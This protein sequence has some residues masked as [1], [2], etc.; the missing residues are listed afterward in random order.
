[1]L[2][3]LILLSI[4][5]LFFAYIDYDEQSYIDST[6]F[7]SVP[8]SGLVI[9]TQTVPRTRLH[10][11]SPGE[12]IITRSNRSIIN[13]TYS[14]Y[15]DAD[16]LSS[17][18]IVYVASDRLTAQQCNAQTSCNLNVVE[19][20]NTTTG[21][22]TRL[23]SRVTP[24]SGHNPYHDV[25]VLNESHILVA[26]TL[27]DRI[28][29]VNINS[30]IITWEWDAQAYLPVGA[31]D[32]GFPADWTHLNDVEALA[33]GRIMVNLR[34]QDQVVFVNRSTGVIDER[35]LGAAGN[36]SILYEQ[37]NP[38]YLESC[39]SVLVADSENNR[40]IEYQYDGSTYR[41]TWEWSDPGLLWPRDADRAPDG[42]TL[43][44]DS[45]GNRVIRVARDGSILWSVPVVNPYEAELMGTGPESS[46]GVCASSANLSSQTV[47]PS[48]GGESSLQV[49]SWNTIRSLIPT[50]LLSGIAF[51]L[52]VWVGI[53][54]LF[55]IGLLGTTSI[56][57]ISLEIY[58]LSYSIQVQSP[59]VL[60]RNKDD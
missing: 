10:P 23:F 16:P 30:G 1:V 43:I 44:T 35:T 41:Q 53:D 47:D 38:D 37:H 9:T 4:A 50:K 32:S 3:C 29:I 5:I 8:E 25:D 45:N 11:S 55:T 48:T 22:T 33:D 60:I 12:I 39:G 2:A 34:N 15:W 7:Q 18:S 26:D 28:F 17:N 24:S 14:S 31:G 56:S 57:W 51:I 6:E 40:V 59:V 21:N 54:Q 42:T 49:R 20:L 19:V 46:G 13:Q 52:P 58:W 27:N 36:H